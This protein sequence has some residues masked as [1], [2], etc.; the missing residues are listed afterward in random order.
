MTAGD[1]KVLVE[2]EGE[3]E[4]EGEDWAVLGFLRVLGV[5][6]SVVD[7]RLVS[8]SQMLIG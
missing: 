5:A 8:G 3:E 6:P 2:E 4:E 7:N 1:T